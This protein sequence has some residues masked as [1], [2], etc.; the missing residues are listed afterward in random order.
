MEAGKGTRK[1]NDITATPTRTTPTTSVPQQGEREQDVPKKLR[2]AM[3][4]ALTDFFGQG[5]R[6]PGPTTAGNPIDT[7]IQRH[8]S[9]IGTTTGKGDS[10]AVVGGQTDDTN[11]WR[12]PLA[13]K[14]QDKRNTKTRGAE[15]EE[16]QTTK[17]P[18]S[19]NEQYAGEQSKG[20]EQ[21]GHTVDLEP[22][23]ALLRKKSP[24]TKISKPKKNKENQEDS[25][26]KPDQTPG[27][28]TFAEESG[29]KKEE[30]EVAV[31]FQCVIGFTIRVDKGSNTKG[32]FDKKLTEGLTFLREYVDPA[33]CIY[34]TERIRGWD[35]SSQNRT[36]QNTS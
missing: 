29:K 32:G 15:V 28:T 1:S 7:V 12:T 10:G 9:T 8:I 31:N 27:K 36:Y 2:S 30:E 22:M 24:K 4:K 16:G 35:L 14:K 25:A 21:A 13:K 23:S 34:Q 19:D 18:R 6:A 33:A 17:K 26:R 3:K 20:T 5:K 11:N